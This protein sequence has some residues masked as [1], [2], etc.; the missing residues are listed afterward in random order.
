LDRL[1]Y[2]N[3]GFILGLEMS[4]RKTNLTLTN[5]AAK[6]LLGKAHTSNLKDVSNEAIPSN[7]SVV[8]EGVFAEVIP[9]AP[10]SSFYTVYS[11]SS[12][13]PGTVEKV[14]FKVVEATGTRYDADGET[15]GGPGDE[16]S[17]FGP[18]G[19][20]L[21]LASD[22]ETSSSNSN[23]G[24]GVF[25]NDSV[26]YSSR[27]A[28]QLIPPF[29]STGN[30]N[31]YQLKLY[32]SSDVEISF[33]DNI[34]WTV[35]Y[36]AGTIFVQ[37]YTASVSGIS[38]VPVSA[39]AYIYVGKYLNDKISDISASAGGDAVTALNNQAENRLVTIGSTTTE[40]DGEANL[41][42]DGSEFILTGSSIFNGALTSSHIVPL[43]DEQ[44]DLGQ[45]NLKYENL[46]AKF[47]D[48]GLMFT[49][50]ND[51]GGTI[52]RGQVVYVKG[53]QGQ[54]P[55][56]ALAAADDASKM[57]AMGLVADGTVNDGNEVRIVTL[58]RLNGFDTSAFSAG[59]TL[60]VQTGSGGVSGSLTN[61]APTGSGALIQNIA[62]V[63]KSDNSGQVRV[64]GA[65][66]TN[67]TP[68][69]DK[70]HIFIGNDSDQA[71]QDSTIFVSSS[72]NKVGINTINAT[73][74]L[75][76]NGTVSASAYL[77]IEA[78]I[79]Y[80]RRA[81]SATITASVSDTILGVS[82]AAAIDIRLPS[83]GDYDAGQYFT[84]KDESGAADTKNITIL[85]SG[86]QT[87]DGQNSIILESPYAAINI[88][89]DGTS[90][91][92]IY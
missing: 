65:G 28:L 16:S 61:S 86:S 87:I 15:N 73:H 91:F 41:T 57:P 90:K 10:G 24:T 77:G 60:Y 31:P 92:F 79:S 9:N 68:N 30:P 84:V 25:V 35:D 72:A 27:G 70:G 58:G 59:E 42:F 2:T 21:Q 44:Y 17:D 88:Y 53:I 81:V 69:L 23:A 11:A 47:L 71:V 49:A 34:D 40:L 62:R 13:D 5:L 83:A 36:Y 67:A 56:I 26:V 14:Y 46:Y 85:A 38:K 4:T 63:L 18:H 7:V 64:G 89:S 6:K 75:T 48:G 54:T 52:S 1:S 51:E 82:G 80:S 29:T 3:N 22:Y 19:Y 78:G 39:S 76:V 43:S 12:G 45:V 55:T 33:T 32:N 8:S 20:Y 50:I 66:R 37:D 74:T